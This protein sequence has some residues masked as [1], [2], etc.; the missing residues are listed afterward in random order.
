[1][2]FS[3]DF[4][5]S[6]QSIIK[7]KIRFLIKYGTMMDAVYFGQFQVISEKIMDSS[8]FFGGRVATNLSTSVY[9][10]T[11]PMRTDTT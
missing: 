9:F 3:F 4:K 2:P 5:Y 7:S 6:V 1:M 10:L 11:K 8:F